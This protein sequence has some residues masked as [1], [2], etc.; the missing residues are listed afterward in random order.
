MGDAAAIAAFADRLVADFPA[1]NVV[2]HNAGIM[3]V[4]E[5]I[6]LAVAEATV[7]TNLLGPIRLTHALL[8]HLLAQ[9]AATLMTV[10]SG[11]AFVPLAAT[12]TSSATKAAPHSWP[13]A[14]R[15]QPTGSASYGDSRVQ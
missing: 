4:E 5:Q 15:H 14:S 12:P 11:L 8:P 1:L 2:V 13:Q 7:A 6:D 10:T 9:P 3:V